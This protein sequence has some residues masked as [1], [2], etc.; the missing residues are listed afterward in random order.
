MPW[1]LTEHADKV[2]VKVLEG[3]LTVS[4]LLREGRRCLAGGQRGLQ[5]LFEADDI[6]F[7]G[8]VKP[9][10]NRALITVGCSCKPEQTD[11]QTV[12]QVEQ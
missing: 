12:T 5:R 7:R 8:G 6:T 10:G 1:P 4:L 11:S 3:L 9:K 2:C